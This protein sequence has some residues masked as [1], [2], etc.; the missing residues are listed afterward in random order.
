MAAIFESQYEYE[1]ANVLTT[2]CDYAMI[3]KSQNAEVVELAD[4]LDSK[5][6]MGNHVWVRVPPSAPNKNAVLEA[7]FLFG[8]EMGRMKPERVLRSNNLQ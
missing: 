6:C 2:I 5:S 7:A 8:I 3:S 4:A 1:Y